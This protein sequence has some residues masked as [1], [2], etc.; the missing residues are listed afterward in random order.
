MN[1]RVLSDDEFNDLLRVDIP[2]TRALTGWQI[3]HGRLVEFVKHFEIEYP[4]RIRYQS[5]KRRYGTAYRRE[6]DNGFW[7]RIAIN[8]RL[9]KAE[10]ANE[11]LLHELCHIIQAERWAKSTGK[12]IMDWYDDSYILAKGEW[13]YSYKRNLYEL[14]AHKFA[15]KYKEEWQL[16]KS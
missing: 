15:A 6:D 3:D 13:G 12:T 1:F 5:G 7:H 4:V 8:Q 14:D 10:R 11:V 16:V 2:A 9:K